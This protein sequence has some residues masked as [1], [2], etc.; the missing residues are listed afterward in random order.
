M[1]ATISTYATLT[2]AIGDFAHRT[3]LITGTPPYSDYFIQAAQ[4]QFEKDIL[5]FNFGVGIALQEFSYSPTLITG[6]V[7]PIPLDWLAPKLL[8]VTDTGGSVWTLTFKQA[9]WLYAN[10]PVRQPTNV[11]AYVAM[12]QLSPCTIS[13]TL[14][15]SGVL[16]IASVSSG[17]VQVGDILTDITGHLPAAT[18]GSAVIVTG[19]SSGN[20]G[21]AG[22]YTAQSCSPLAPTYTIAAETMT[23]GGAVLT[24]GPYPDGPYQIQGT[25]YQQAPLLSSGGNSTNWMVLSA[26]MTLLAYCFWQ[27]GLFLKDSALATQWFTIAQ[28]GC[29]GLVDKDKAR[30]WAAGTLQVETA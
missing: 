19:Q 30:R 15:T 11:P 7:A 13:A 5:D 21:A 28:N 1:P 6:G 22:N 23:G 2:Q 29:K 25:Y 20:T 12:D 8:T 14:N 3:D 24:F 26:P 4:E 27:A 16:G 18:P 9:A 17:I 10:Y